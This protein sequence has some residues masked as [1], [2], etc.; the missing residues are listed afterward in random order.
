MEQTLSRYLATHP[1]AAQFDF[2]SIDCRTTFCEIQATGV[3]ESTRPVWSQVTYDVQQQ[4]WSEFD[5]TGS[6]DFRAQD[7]RPLYTVTFHRKQPRR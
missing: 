5:M 7:G 4:A 3:D 2:R 1:K 6:E